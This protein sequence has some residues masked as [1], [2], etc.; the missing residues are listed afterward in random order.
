[1]MNLASIGR[2]SWPDIYH[3]QELTPDLK[4]SREE[5]LLV[6]FGGGS[7]IDILDFRKR[8]LTSLVVF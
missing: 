3:F 4:G 2:K 6:D 5:I 8:F 1:M 7:G